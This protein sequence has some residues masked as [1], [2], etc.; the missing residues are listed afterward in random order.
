[1]NEY[2]FTVVNQILE[3]VLVICQKINSVENTDLYVYIEQSSKLCFG[4]SL[5]R[6][7]IFYHT[8]TYKYNDFYYLVANERNEHIVS[9]FL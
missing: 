5:V 4:S 8:T 1:M 6:L 7:S 3:V 9:Y 2:L